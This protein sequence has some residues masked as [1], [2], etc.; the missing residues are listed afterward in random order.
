MSRDIRTAALV[1]AA[2]M[3]LW[4]CG[5]KDQ[6][7]PTTP[8]VPV[9]PAPAPTPAP[10]DPQGI[11]RGT[12]L[13]LDSRPLG[14]IPVRTEFGATTTTDA[15]GAYTLPFPVKSGLSY[16][17]IYG[18]NDDVETFRTSFNR[19]DDNVQVYPVRVQPRLDL[20]D[21]ALSST[22]S[23]VDL[24][25]FTGEA[26]DS[27]YCSPCKRVRLHSDRPRKVVLT[28]DWAGPAPLQLWAWIGSPAEP[29]YPH[30]ETGHVVTGAAE[31]GATRITVEVM[32][33]IGDTLVHVGVPESRKGTSLPVVPFTL[34]IGPG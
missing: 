31:Q 9:Q 16:G 15:S 11:V 25:Y 26:Y 33:Q 10:P 34:S 20:I 12:V 2:V 24:G 30:V 28:L 29:E 14:G 8:S 19:N 1:M 17:S 22:V 5:G 27:D 3:S 21:G 7:L 6:P 13:G 23:G 18:G 4:S 32:A